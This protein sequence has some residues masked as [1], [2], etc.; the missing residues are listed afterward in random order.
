MG[1][2]TFVVKELKR[3]D[4]D[5]NVNPKYSKNVVNVDLDLEIQRL[6]SEIVLPLKF[7]LFWD[8]LKWGRLF[9]I[10]TLEKEKNAALT[11]RNLKCRD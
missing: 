1:W 9:R 10:P 2:N 8:L 3:F 6:V 5:L 4:K 11:D 7:R